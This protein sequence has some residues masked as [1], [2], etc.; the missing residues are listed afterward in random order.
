MEM[1]LQIT[2]RGMDR[3]AAVEQAVRERAERLDKFSDEIMSCRVVVEAPHHHHH[4]GNLYHVSIEVHLHGHKTIAITRD[5]KQ[6]QA[7][8]DIYVAVRDAFDAAQ[9]R[10]EDHARRRRGKVKHHDVPAHGAIAELFP[11]DD[12]GTIATQDDRLV[13]F[14]RNSVV[15]ADFD[16][17][18]VAAEVRFVEEPGE[19]GPQASTVKL[20][21]K[22]H[23]AG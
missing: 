2:F 1:P 22:H 21:G 11:Q 19:K 23:L 20:I 7:H 8:Q 6:H 10:I 5:P 4:K 12:Y 17:L 15:G 18:E 9:R 3:S 16:D 14:H 13:Y